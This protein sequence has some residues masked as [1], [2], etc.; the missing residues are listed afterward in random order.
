MSRR[1]TQVTTRSGDTGESS[2]ADGTRLPKSDARFD[3]IGTVDELNSHIGVLLAEALAE[4]HTQVLQSAQ[5]ALFDVGGGLA[6]PGS[7]TFPSVD[8]LEQEIMTLNKQLPPLTEFVLP[9]GSRASALAHVCRTVCRRAERTLW[10]I[11]PTADAGAAYLNRLSD[12][13]FVL[14]RTLNAGADE[15]QWRGPNK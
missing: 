9:G 4:R 12:Y 11:S 8:E 2:L 5:Q 10:A 13:F 14:A 3:A 15:L 1:I 7:E 6:V